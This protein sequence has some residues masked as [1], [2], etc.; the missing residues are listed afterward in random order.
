LFAGDSLAADFGVERLRWLIR[1]RWGALAGMFAL[2]MCGLVGIVPG[3]AWQVIGGT[4]LVGIV[5]NSV[6]WSVYS[7]GHGASGSRR[8]A[9][10]QALVDMGM[11]TVVLWACGGLHNPFVGFY[12]LHVALMA[13]LTCP[14][15]TFKA[16]VGSIVCVAALAATEMYPAWR[17]GVWNPA[18]PWDLLSWGVAFAFMVG[19]IAYLVMHAVRQLQEREIALVAARDRAALEYELL[20]TTLT[21]LDAGLEVLT[22]TGDVL[23]HNKRVERLKAAMGAAAVPVAAGGMHEHEDDEGVRRTT[24]AVKVDGQERVYERMSFSLHSPNG[25]SRIMN[26]YVDR[27]QAVLQEG[28]LVLAERLVS[29]GRVAQGVAHELNT[30]LATIRTLA[31]DMR[32]ALKTLTDDPAQ[33]AVVVADVDE[34]AKLVADETRRLGRITQSLLAGGDL[35]QARIDGDAPLSAVI[36]RARAIV[37]AGVADA[38]KVEVAAGVDPLRVSADPDRLMQIMVNLLQN[39]L[40]SVRGKG[41]ARIAVGAYRDGDEI[42]IDV[43][44]NGAGIEAKVAAR[45]FEPFATTKPQGTGLGLYTSYMM[46]RRMGGTI[47][48]EPRAE[49][50]ARARLRLPR[51]RR[52]QRSPS[53]HR[54]KCART[55]SASVPN[56]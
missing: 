47:A 30:P 53:V 46:V 14:A 7:R 39:A 51:R 36:V 50:G 3:A 56:P 44:D 49:G 1:L 20:V 28:R 29:L 2:S 4:V 19:S 5:Y 52:A 15:A 13:I 32:A 43:D 12:V 42:V 35:V 40:D 10:Y 6:L 18:P 8:A 41:D 22:E 9:M 11:L 55:R 25:A 38:V 26:L 37:F 21:E 48:L 45:L 27:T 33:R 31:T 16:F 24:H 17:I 34:S 23:W 54:S